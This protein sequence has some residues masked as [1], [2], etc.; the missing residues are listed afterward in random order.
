ME[1]KPLLGDGPV[2]LR[3][4]PKRRRRLV[5][6]IVVERRDG[7]ERERGKIKNTG[8]Q[9][10]RL[11]RRR[12]SR[13]VS[14]IRNESIDHEAVLQGVPPLVE[15]ES[16]LLRGG[17]DGRDAEI[18]GGGGGGRRRRRGRRRRM[19]LGRRVRRTGEHLNDVL[20]RGSVG[21]D[22]GGGIGIGVRSG[23]SG[24]LRGERRRGNLGSTIGG[25]AARIA[26]RRIHTELI[27]SV[28]GLR[29]DLH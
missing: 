23:E 13:T 10:L 24:S 16:L 5:K 7:T 21:L 12:K 28:H 11:A 4:I 27:V 3:R 19:I 26:F 25:A 6:G 1:I 29:H 8:R 22:E 15:L 20:E 9:D 14:V 18:L 17:L 2:L